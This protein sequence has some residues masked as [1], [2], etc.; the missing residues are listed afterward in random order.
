M[1]GE[2]GFVFHNIRTLRSKSIQEI[3]GITNHSSV[4]TTVLRSTNQAIGWWLLR[5]RNIY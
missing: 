1:V 4:A 5:H 3:V 2:V